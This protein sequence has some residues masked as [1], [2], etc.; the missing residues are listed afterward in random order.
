MVSDED[1]DSNTPFCLAVESG[2]LESVE[3]LLSCG[4]SVNHC[5][6]LR[7]Y[8]I[9]NA[10]SAGNVEIVK[11]LVRVRTAELLTDDP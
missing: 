11:L 1:I 3:L 2:S 6:N 8:P 7:S 4:S 10:S 9:H 5:N